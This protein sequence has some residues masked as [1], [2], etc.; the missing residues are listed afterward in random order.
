ML[1]LPGLLFVQTTGIRVGHHTSGVAWAA[2]LA[3]NVPLYFVGA[4]LLRWLWAGWHKPLTKKER[5]R[6][7]KAEAESGGGL[8]RGCRAAHEPSTR[9]KSLPGGSF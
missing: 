3:V 9:R 2:M 5:K 4:M 8:A 7:A 6:A 1:A